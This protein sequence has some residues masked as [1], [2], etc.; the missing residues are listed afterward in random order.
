[1]TSALLHK[2][3]RVDLVAGDFNGTAWRSSNRC[4][5]STI[6]EAFSDRHFL[7]PPCSTPLFGPVS[8]P[9]LW[10]DVC[11]F[12]KPADSDRYWKAR[13]HGA[14]GIPHKALGLRDHDRS[15]HHETWLHLDLIERWDWSRTHDDKYDQRIQLNEREIPYNYGHRKRDTAKL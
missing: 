15:S 11:G 1:M 4:N 2:R 8:I 13:K 12:L 6:E 5:R 9:D 7:T 3:F 10:T 14:I